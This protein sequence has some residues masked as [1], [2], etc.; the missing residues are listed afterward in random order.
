MAPDEAAV[1][2]V[3]HLQSRFLAVLGLF[4]LALLLLGRTLCD[5]MLVSDKSVLIPLLLD[6]G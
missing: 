4:L 2:L 6:E 5:S 1:V 3:Q